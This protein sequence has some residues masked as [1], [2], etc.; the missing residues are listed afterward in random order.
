MKKSHAQ[1]TD[2]LDTLKAYSIILT[3]DKDRA[4]DLLQNTLLRILQ[5]IDEYRAIG[6]FEPWAKK[7]MLNVFR[8]EVRS[9][10]LRS[11]HFVDG[12]NHYEEEHTTYSY[13]A[14]SDSVYNTKELINIIRELPGRQSKTI[15]MRVDG[16]R[17]NEIAERLGMSVGNVKQAIFAARSNIKRRLKE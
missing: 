11:M 9:S 13:A 7:V 17:Y 14:E 1:V 6:K 16:Y 10:S 4:D 2:I 5:N 15:A 8:N 3:A 12:Y